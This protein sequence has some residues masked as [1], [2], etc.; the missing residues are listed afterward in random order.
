MLRYLAQ[1]VPV[2]ARA[3][4]SSP[5]L[6]S[7]IRRRV[8][9]GHIDLNRHMN[10][11]AYPEVFE[12]G[13]VDWF[14]RSGAWSRWS[15]M[16]VRPLVA[17]QHIVYRRELTW[18]A[19]YEIDSRAVATDGRLLRLEQHVVVGDRVHT[20]AEV[21]L[22][23]VGRDGVLSPDEVPPICEG[24]LVPALPVVDWQVQPESERGAA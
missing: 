21:R 3:R 5:S 9:L 6:A 4:L 19:A 2:A 17:E 22:I 11:A 23:F 8:P 14:M 20:R 24:L 10:Q 1:L 16:G 7:R 13:R 12:L 18:R 15:E